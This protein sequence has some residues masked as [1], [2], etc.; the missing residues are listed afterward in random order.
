MEPIRPQVDAYPLDWLR[1]APL[2]RNWFFEER[3][4]NCRLTG[5]F[6]AQLSETSKLWK[7][8]LGPFAEWML[9]T[10]WSCSSSTSKI[11]APATRLTHDRKRE[12]KGIPAQSLTDRAS[13]EGVLT[14]AASSSNTQM[15][16]KLARLERFD[17]VAQSRRAESQRRQA[18]AQKA[19][20]P[21]DKPDWP[22]ER[23]YLEKI[24]PRLAG[25][26]V[27]TIV[28]APSVTEPYA[29]NIRAGR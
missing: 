1:R 27:S 9:H 28:T 11:E 17:P 6:T 10:L 20:S 26:A 15:I 5:E 24:Q 8:A 21:T 7:Q 3:D 22:N 14:L 2:Q 25:I 12:A 29:T 18:V 19:W 23:V 16:P 13:R 4:G